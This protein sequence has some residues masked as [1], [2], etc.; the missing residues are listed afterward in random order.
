M[1][2]KGHFIGGK[3]VGVCS[4]SIISSS[5]KIK[6]EWSFTSTLPYAFMTCTEITL[7]TVR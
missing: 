7:I 4:W 1:N 6:N 3:A 2:N 5:V